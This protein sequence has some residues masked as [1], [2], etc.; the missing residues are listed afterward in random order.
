VTNVRNVT[1]ITLPSI[2]HSTFIDTLNA[3]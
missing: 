3:V 2:N 1:I